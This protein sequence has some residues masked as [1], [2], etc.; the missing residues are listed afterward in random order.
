M[1]VYLEDLEAA[2]T[3]YTAQWKEHLQ[4]DG[5]IVTE[6]ENSKPAQPNLNKRSLLELDDVIEEILERN[7][8]FVTQIEEIIRK[9]MEEK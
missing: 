8:D 9:K 2:H 7:P 5:H 3:R 6:K 1:R 4:G